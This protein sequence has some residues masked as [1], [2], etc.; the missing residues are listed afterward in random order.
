[1]DTNTA[2][3]IF[4]ICFSLLLAIVIFFSI[5]TGSLKPKTLSFELLAQSFM[6]L[7]HKISEY[8][9]FAGLLL[10]IFQHP[11]GPKVLLAGS[12]WWIVSMVLLHL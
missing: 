2:L 10:S 11:T 4:Y 9:L 3:N 12:I 7:F 8:A 5:K 1:M 6:S